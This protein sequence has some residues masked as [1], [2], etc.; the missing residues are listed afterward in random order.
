MPGLPFAMSGLFYA[1]PLGLLSNSTVRACVSRLQSQTLLLLLVLSL[2]LLTTFL[3]AFAQKNSL[4]EETRVAGMPTDSLFTG[5][6]S[7][8]EIDD[9]T[10][11]GNTAFSSELLSAVIASR[12][13]EAGIGRRITGYI[14]RELRRNPASP[15]QFQTVLRKIEQSS[16]ADIRYF[17]KLSAGADTT[18]LAVYYRQNGFHRVEV[19][20][21]FF[22]NPQT[23]R[24]SLIFRIVENEPTPLDTIVYYGLETL[25]PELLPSF[26]AAKTLAH[27]TRFSQSAVTE[28]NERILA[29]L[30]DNGYHTARYRKPILSFLDDENRDSV[31]VVFDIG[32]RKRISG[33]HYIDS[34][35][36]YTY[37]SPN[38]PQAFVELRVGDW[39]NEAAL[40]RSV[41]NLYNFGLFDYAVIDTTSLFE[42]QTDSTLAMRVLTRTRKIHNTDFGTFIGQIANTSLL[43]AGAS[44]RYENKNLL[45]N[46][47]TLGVQAQIAFVD[48]NTLFNNLLAGNAVNARIEGLLSARFAY[49]LFAKLFGRR[50]DLESRLS[51]SWQSLAFVSLAAPLFLETG[52]LY[53]SLPMILPQQGWLNS[54]FLEVNLDRQRPINFE[55]TKAQALASAKTDVERTI[56][57]QQLFQYEILNNLYT[58]NSTPFLTSTILTFGARGD[59][60]DNLFNPRKGYFL[61]MS[62]DVAIPPGASQ[63]IRLSGDIRWFEAFSKQ[64]VLAARF[65][66][67]H[68]ILLNP[69]QA[70]VPIERHYF[71][72]GSNSVRGWNVRELR[73][74]TGEQSAVLPELGFVGQFIGSGSLMEGSIEWRYNFAQEYNE[75][76][77]FFE[78]Q[79]SRLG[80]AG[81]VDFGNA[82]NSF[83]EPTANYGKLPLGE[84]FQNTAI[85]AGAGIRWDTSVG[86][87]RVDAALRVYDPAKRQWFFMLPNPTIPAIIQNLFNLQIGLGHTF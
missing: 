59:H 85:A 68:T 70:F 16:D 82:F 65:R 46:A 37:L 1:V 17:D 20:Y 67:G 14:L 22:R 41:N 57:E 4:I 74:R 69:E 61:D 38:V 47:Q 5:S 72:G 25:A 58:Q 53:A 26:N 9:I 39:Y 62:A 54:L 64:S 83:L 6:A 32:K 28:Q 35:A 11:V 18:A 34:S 13:S 10:F 78:R 60:R 73:V 29:F 24:N 52:K 75:Y 79:L 66:A 2:V 81:F 21:A 43:E 8:Y 71:A 55:A 49:P 80:V 63:F 50:V 48:L 51:Y 45:G 77:T 27:G 44:A 23:K 7:R 3:P 40:V 31:T 12:P 33:I 86:P 76:G 84:I 42:P 15:K 30:R 56:V 19:D 36:S 87:F